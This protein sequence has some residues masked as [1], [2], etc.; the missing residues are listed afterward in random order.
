MVILYHW[1]ERKILRGD[2]VRLVLVYGAHRMQIIIIGAG[3]G[4]LTAA[5]TLLRSGNEVQV[6]EQ[7]P[8][9]RQVGAGIQVSPNATRLLQCL[10]LADQLRRTAVR[11]VA[12]EMRRWQD[13][14]VGLTHAP[15]C[16]TTSFSDPRD[17][18]ASR[19]CAR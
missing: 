18:S 9:L 14:P 7:A 2:D 16:A 13:G 8:E 5:L 17:A 11:P 12:I 6:F 19:G 10:G 1:R 15:G 4:G 3:I